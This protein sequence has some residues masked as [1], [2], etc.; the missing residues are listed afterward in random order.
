MM[1]LIRMDINYIYT[2]VAYDICF[3]R[4]YLSAL[5]FGSENITCKIKNVMIIIK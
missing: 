5:D 3:L 4:V 1:L 2:R